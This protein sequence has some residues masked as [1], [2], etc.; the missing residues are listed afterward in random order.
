MK[1]VRRLGVGGKLRREELASEKKKKTSC[2][3]G[4]VMQDGEK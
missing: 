4:L 3:K 1:M 2:E